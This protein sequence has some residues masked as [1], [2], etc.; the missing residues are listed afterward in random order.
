MNPHSGMD[1]NDNNDNNNNRR[2]K[3]IAA[4]PMAAIIVAAALLSGLIS[5]T[6]SSYE[7][8]MAQQNLTGTTSGTTQEVAEVRSLQLVLQHKQLAAAAAQQ[9]AAGIVRMGLCL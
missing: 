4:I 6:G 3:A 2:T 5:F 9:L 1:G 8:A 7:P